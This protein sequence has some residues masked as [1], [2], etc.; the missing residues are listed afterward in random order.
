MVK[1]VWTDRALTDLEDIAEYI[2]KDSVKYARLTIRK[3]I[4]KTKILEKQ[5]T[6]GRIVPEINDNKFRELISGN[7]RI[8]YEHN[9][10]SVNIL[11]VHNSKR[12][13]GRRNLFSK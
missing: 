5:P 13:L 8:I 6:I 9:K 7:Y 12:D 2:E 10:L 4:A 1:I 11:T 3:L